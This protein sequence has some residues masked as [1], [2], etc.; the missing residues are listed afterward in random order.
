MNT[1]STLHSCRKNNN[2]TPFQKLLISK[3]TYAR[4]TAANYNA[5][6]N[7]LMESTNNGRNATG[8]GISKGVTTNNGALA[9]IDYLS[10][11]TSSKIIFPNGTI[12]NPYTICSLTRYSGPT[13]G[14]I[15]QSVEQNWLLGHWFGNRGVHYNGSWRTQQS[16]VGIKNN[17]LNF[18]GTNGGNVPSNILCDGV[19]IGISTGSDSLVSSLSINGGV[20]YPNE[21]SDFEFSQVLI[22]NVVLTATEM[23]TVS[24]AI[25]NY[26]ATGI[27]I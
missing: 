26:L 8:S 22:W 6:T 19:S 27:L 4:Y 12:P 15:L 13:T 14:R 1:I 9:T 2:L 17:W 25:A 5:V 3:P 10:G 16:S 23:K 21:V 7:V 18:C 11:S 20:L 24:N